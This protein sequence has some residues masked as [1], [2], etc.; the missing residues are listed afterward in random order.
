[1]IY[2]RLQEVYKILS[3]T[4]TRTLTRNQPLLNVFTSSIYREE[5]KPPKIAPGQVQNLRLSV[6]RAVDR[7]KCAIDRSVNR[8]KSSVITGLN[9]NVGR[10]P[11]RPTQ[12]GSY[13]LCNI[14][15]PR[16]ALSPHAAI[17]THKII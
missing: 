3:R 10:S 12:L 5:K 17:H 2:T 7:P 8:K 13:S 16:N 1:M 14:D 9:E 6:D 4:L 11:G 15:R